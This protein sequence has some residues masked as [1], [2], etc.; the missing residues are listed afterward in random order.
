M[1][2]SAS[3]YVG[4]LWVVTF[5]CLSFSICEMGSIIWLHASKSYWGLARDDVYIHAVSVTCDGD[6][7]EIQTEEEHKRTIK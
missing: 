1:L 6:L 3:C 2:C 7:L 4:E 5:S